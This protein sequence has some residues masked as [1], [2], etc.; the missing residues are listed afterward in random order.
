MYL[1]RFGIVGNE[2]SN[3]SWSSPP[4][5][6]WSTKWRENLESRAKLCQSAPI[7]RAQKDGANVAWSPIFAKEKVE[8]NRRSFF[9]FALNFFALCFAEVAHRCLPHELRKCIHSLL[10]RGTPRKV[11]LA[12]DFFP[13]K[14]E[15][16]LRQKR[17]SYT[18]FSWRMRNCGDGKVSEQNLESVRGFLLKISPSRNSIAM[19]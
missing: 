6:K 15:L 19:H 9:L 5:K 8:E 3:K 11:L 7:A 2:T 16:G 1:L 17:R 18:R 10:L 14:K 12:E 4:A 13:L